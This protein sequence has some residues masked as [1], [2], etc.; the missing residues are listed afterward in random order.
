MTRSL[1]SSKFLTLLPL[2]GIVANGLQLPALVVFAINLGAMSVLSEC[3]NRC[4]NAISI[5]TKRLTTELLKG[6]FGNSV[7]LMVS[8]FFF[9]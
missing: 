6:T 2:V 1:L 8:V 3:I 5:N 4:I 9:V 7:E